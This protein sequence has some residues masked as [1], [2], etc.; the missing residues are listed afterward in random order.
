LYCIGTPF[1]EYSEQLTAAHVGK[2]TVVMG[3]WRAPSSHVYVELPL[4]IGR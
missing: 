1:A 4:C 2:Q 3:F